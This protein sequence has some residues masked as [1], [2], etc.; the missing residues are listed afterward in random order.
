M[1]SPLLVFPWEVATRIERGFRQVA[2]YLL[3][4][5]PFLEHDI[6]SIDR[7]LSPRVYVMNSLLSSFAFGIVVGIA[8][9][10]IFG[11]NLFEKFIAGFGAF[12]YVSFSVFMIN[13]I[14]P[15]L[16]IRDIANAINKELGFAIRDLLIQLKGGV[17]LYEA[18]ISIAEGG[19]GELSKMFKRVI[20]LVNS[21]YTDSAALQKVA[22]ESKS[23]FLRKIIW[24]LANGV[25]KGG[26]LSSLLE[27]ISTYIDRYN[28][29]TIKSYL[30]TMNMVIL[31]FF[32][33]GITLPSLGIVFLV[34]LSSVGGIPLD[35]FTLMLM[36]FVSLF[37]QATILYYIRSLKPPILR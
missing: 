6:K 22:L 4:V 5:V 28:E 21:G 1:V 23:D 30:S 12:L 18:M 35:I 25:E 27:S 14:F 31:I 13:V 8:V 19:Y 29:R 7:N 15:K 24:Q 16:K 26:N 11:I 2:I 36:L 9:F 10:L 37:M 17:S 3:R 20:F 34:V 33:I 32:L